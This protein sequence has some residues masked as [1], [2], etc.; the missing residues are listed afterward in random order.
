MTEQITLVLN[1][2]EL[3]SLIEKHIHEQRKEIEIKSISFD[4]RYGAGEILEFTGVTIQAT[5]V[6]FL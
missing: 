2:S 5:P 1:K 3:T 6:V 4:V